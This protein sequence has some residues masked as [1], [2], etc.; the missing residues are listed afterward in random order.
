MAPVP[1]GRLSMTTVNPC[2]SD[3]RSDIA[4]VALSTLP[5]AGTVTMM[6]SGLVLKVAGRVN[7]A[8]CAPPHDTINP[9]SAARISVLA[10]LQAVIAAGFGADHGVDIA[11]FFAYPVVHHA[12]PGANRSHCFP[13]LPFEG[14]LPASPLRF[15]C[16]AHQGGSLSRV[17]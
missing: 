2:R 11:F 6:R 13:T 10:R 3:S 17:R 9:K 7:A 15:N 5:P 14:I 4:R 8:A 16:R 1:P 12:A